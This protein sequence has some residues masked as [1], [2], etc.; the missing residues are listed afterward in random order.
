MLT[1]DWAHDKPASHHVA[2][3]GPVQSGFGCWSLSRDQH[4]PV[5]TRTESQV[6]D[7]HLSAAIWT[8]LG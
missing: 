6:V 7:G 2:S 8:S 3:T 5:P 4:H 1:Q